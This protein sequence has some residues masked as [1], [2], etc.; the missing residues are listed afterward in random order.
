MIIINLLNS[1]D[2]FI[3]LDDLF[4]MIYSGKWLDVL[5]LRAT[6]AARR[7]L[8]SGR[9]LRLFIRRRQYGADPVTR[10]LRLP[11]FG[12]HGCRCGIY[13]WG[14]LKGV[15]KMADRWVWKRRWCFSVCVAG[16]RGSGRSAARAWTEGSSSRSCSVS[17]ASM[18]LIPVSVGLFSQETSFITDLQVLCEGGWVR[19]W[20]GP[21]LVLEHP[22]DGSCSAAAGG[23]GRR[24]CCCCTCRCHRGF[25]HPKPP[26]STGSIWIRTWCS[27]G[28][29]SEGQFPLLLLPLLSL[30]L[31]PESGASHEAQNRSSLPS[32]A[33]YRPQ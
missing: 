1:R 19:G 2:I 11:R 13:C 4:K 22:H 3:L 28:W 20:L 29:G 31:Q 33:G 27:S 8:V 32:S 23:W 9:S 14:V 26:V 30:P 10:R 21:V 24:C 5:I 17:A 18:S 6:R 16:Q 15:G 12:Q 25:L 7:A